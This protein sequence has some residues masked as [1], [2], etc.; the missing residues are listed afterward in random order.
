MASAT[1]PTYTATPRPFL[2]GMAWGPGSIIWPETAAPRRVTRVHEGR[3]RYTRGTPRFSRVHRHARVGDP[4]WLLKGFLAG[5]PRATGE[6]RNLI[7]RAVSCHGRVIPKD[8]RE[9]VIQETIL[10]LWRELANPDRRVASLPAFVKRIAFC[11]CVDWIRRDRR[12]PVVADPEPIVARLS[13]QR[14]PDQ[15]LL[16]KEKRKMGDRV[17]AGLRDSHRELIRLR[18]QLDLGYHEIAR[19]QGRSEDAVRRQW[20]DCLRE[21]RRVCAQLEHDEIHRG[22]GAP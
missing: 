18:V 4:D 8:K 20:C 3:G 12:E 13:H 22:R 17:L 15:E 10:D 21:A 11:R 9:D 19:R 6:V 1:M 16:S 5:D 2:P 14:S 7:A